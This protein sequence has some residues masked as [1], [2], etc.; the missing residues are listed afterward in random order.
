VL[1]LEW[2]RHVEG[3]LASLVGER[4][5]ELVVRVARRCQFQVELDGRIE[6]DE[7][8]LLDPDGNALEISE[9]LGTGRREGRR[10]P[11]HAGRSNP[12]SASDAAATLV[13]Y[14]AGEEVHRAP[15]RL[16]PGERVTLRP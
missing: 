3:G 15:V 1:P 9:F 7:L 13:L 2:G 14:R 5:E 8:A 10:Q 11:L 12:M 6:A 16:V 4:P